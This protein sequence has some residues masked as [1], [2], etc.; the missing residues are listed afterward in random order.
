[1]Q[2]GF[3]NWSTAASIQSCHKTLLMNCLYSQFVSEWALPME[4]G[5][6]A[7]KRLSSWLN[8]LTAADPGYMQ[9]NIP[10]SA[11]GLYVYAPLESRVTDTTLTSNAQP[12]LD[13]T[14]RDGPT[15][16]INATLYRP[17]LCDPPCLERYYEAFE[18]LMR[19][20]G[21]RG[22]VRLTVCFITVPVSGKYI[23]TTPKANAGL[24]A[25]SDL[26]GRNPLSTSRTS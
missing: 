12:Y 18:W 20:R 14:C 5:A 16:Y 8:Q 26:P 23:G 4:K 10:F 11:Y 13:P 25:F 1:M 3:S 2:Y 21:C 9:H 17:Y 15:V 19:L 22:L 24:A 7:L 6:V